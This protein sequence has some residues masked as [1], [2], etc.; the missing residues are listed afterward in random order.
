MRILAYAVEAGGWVIL[1]AFIAL[2]TA[3]IT[4]LRL[5]NQGRTMSR[6][7]STMD[8]S[9]WTHDLRDAVKI[10]TALFITFLV[11]VILCSIP[12]AINQDRLLAWLLPFGLAAWLVMELR[13]LRLTQPATQVASYILVEPTTEEQTS[14]SS[15]AAIGQDDY[16]LSSGVYFTETASKPQ[17]PVN[18]LPEF[19]AAYQDMAPDLSRDGTTLVFMQG[20]IDS[21]GEDYYRMW[22]ERLGC[23]L[24]AENLSAMVSS[25]ASMVFTDTDDSTG[26]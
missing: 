7:S 14:V 9:R 6:N 5:T 13:Y 11:I 12:L 16:D 17:E 25:D 1:V 19:F 4:A 22:N 2:L 20:S 8:N 24:V 23:R 15:V 21:T 26:Y 18:E 10:T 3:Y